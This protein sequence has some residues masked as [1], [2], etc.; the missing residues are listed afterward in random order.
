LAIAAWNLVDPGQQGKVAN[1]TIVFGGLPASAHVTLQALD[2]DHGNVLKEYASIGSPLIPTPAQVSKL[3]RATAL[4]PAKTLP[5]EGNKLDVQ[6]S[7]NALVLIMV[8]P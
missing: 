2:S 6:L 3:N 1:L 8:G 5:I 7:P 4:P